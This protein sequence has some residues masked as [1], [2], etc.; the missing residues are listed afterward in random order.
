MATIKTPLRIG[1]D[2]PE[3][4][5]QAGEV[6]GPEH[7]G[8]GKDLTDLAANV[9]KYP[10]VN[11][12][13]T[14]YDFDTP[15]GGGGGGGDSLGTG[16][17]AGGGSGIIP[18][19]TTA[20]CQ[21]LFVIDAGFPS[22]FQ[23][24]LTISPSGTDIDS[25]FVGFWHDPAH[26]FGSVLDA[27]T[28]QYT[29]KGYFNSGTGI[30]TSTL[31]RQDEDE[32]RLNSKDVSGTKNSDVVV[33]NA[34]ISITKQQKGALTMDATGVTLK[35]I[36]NTLTPGTL[37]LRAEDVPNSVSRDITIVSDY[38]TTNMVFQN[39]NGGFDFNTT[40][41]ALIPPR[42]TTAQ[43]DAL[44][45]DEGWT[46]RNI[47]DHETQVFNSLTNSWEGL[48]V[49]GTGW[50]GDSLGSGF[51]AGSGSGTVNS[52]SVLTC[53]DGPFDARVSF[54]GANTATSGF[55]FFGL[56]AE[57]GDNVASFG[58]WKEDQL[59][60][61]SE[62]TDGTNQCNEYTFATGKQYGFNETTV[63]INDNGVSVGKGSGLVAFTYEGDY[64]AYLMANDRRVPD[65]G[66]VKKIAIPMDN[67]GLG[68]TGYGGDF[69]WRTSPN[70]DNF[71][72]GLVWGA[73]I[74]KTT[75]E[76][77]PGIP[78]YYVWYGGIDDGGG[79]AFF[80]SNGEERNFAFGSVLP[81]TGLQEIIAQAN[82]ISI[83]ATDYAIPGGNVA[84]IDLFPGSDMWFTNNNTQGNF[85]FES[86]TGGVIFPRLTTSQRNALSPTEV[87]T[88]FC[89]DATAND[90]S[91]GVIQ[92]YSGSTWKNHW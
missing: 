69:V 51:T 57:D 72:G 87:P 85:R 52:N 11:A 6:V 66:T 28:D 53:I 79:R 26:N 1:D 90:G 30:S 82:S 54:F 10:K 4:N 61:S 78:G 84:S 77:V 32:I 8:T 15:S 50:G 38:G 36:G 58:F 16:F 76:I 62:F 7:G 49:P 31:F 48:A 14:G 92:T 25:R 47:D 17:T 9:G 63:Q 41:G 39:S 13:G 3:Q 5:F 56:R 73:S 68:L 64:S 45:P 40:T 74:N 42:L 20:T 89:T 2:T 86:T 91:T 46:I 75:G 24:Q 34:Q 81:G 83:R 37:T 43:R 80:A 70:D 21:D 67:T 29:V 12:A 27:G 60:F 23:S 88:I 59:Y 65:V 35:T 22:G 71:E 19:E 55:R 44:T 18:S 33:A